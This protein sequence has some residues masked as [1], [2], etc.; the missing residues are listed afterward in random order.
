MKAAISGTR[1]FGQH[2]HTDGSCISLAAAVRRGEGSVEFSRRLVDACSGPGSCSTV[3]GTVVCS[4]R[5]DLQNYRLL[6]QPAPEP[7][8]Q[9]GPS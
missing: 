2:K 1:N 7:V 4:P 9:S 3:P 8:H 5:Q 6:R